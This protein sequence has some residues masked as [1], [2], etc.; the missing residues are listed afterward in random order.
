MHQFYRQNFVRNVLSRR[1]NAK[2]VLQFQEKCTYKPILDLMFKA[3]LLK[4][5]KP[6]ETN[7]KMVRLFSSWQISLSIKILQILLP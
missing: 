7:A 1:S 4:L 3:F 5:R 2:S 6:P